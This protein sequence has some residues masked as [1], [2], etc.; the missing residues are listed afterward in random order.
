MEGEP[1]RLEPALRSN[2]QRW[3]V[4]GVGKDRWPLAFIET[5]GP[6]CSKVG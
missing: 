1:Q 4:V 3:K 5:P 2:R 6:G